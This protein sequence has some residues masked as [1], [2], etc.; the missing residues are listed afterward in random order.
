MANPFEGGWRPSWARGAAERGPTANDL[1][2]DV[3][4]AEEQST[5]G[6]MMEGALGGLGYVGSLLDK[7]FG[8]RGLRG[9]LG[10]RPEE[11]LS[12]IPFS[13]TL[14][15]TKPENEVTGRDLLA[16]TGL[17]SRRQPGESFSWSDDLPGMAAEILLDP[18][19]YLSLGTT[20]A[21]KAAKQAGTLAGGLK[22]ELRAGQR[23]LNW[24]LPFVMDDPLQV[25]SGPAFLD[26]MGW[27]RS[28]V[29]APTRGADWLANTALGVTPFA[30]AQRRLYDNVIEPVGRQ[31]NRL[32]APAVKEAAS[33]EG[34]DLGRYMTE[35]EALLERQGLGEAADR[36]AELAQLLGPNPTPD[37]VRDV[38]AALAAN[39]EYAEKGIV[40]NDLFKTAYRDT[41]DEMRK[42]LTKSADT[43]DE[44]LQNLN[45]W[46]NPVFNNPRGTLNA[47]NQALYDMSVTPTNRQFISQQLQN[48]APSIERTR[49]RDEALASGLKPAEVDNV[50]ALQDQYARGGIAAGNYQNIDD[51]YKNLRATSGGT[52]APG[53][54]LQEQSLRTAPVTPSST[55]LPPAYWASESG[56]GAISAAAAQK[57]ALR[58]AMNE[59]AARGDTAAAEEYLRLY[60]S[61]SDEVST[62]PRPDPAAALPLMDSPF[63]FAAGEDPATDTLRSLAKAQGAGQPKTVMEGL[64]VIGLS[65]SPLAPVA[66]AVLGV[67][68][69]ASLGRKVVRN[70]ELDPAYL[71]RQEKVRLP[72]DA[73]AQTAVHEFTHAATSNNL[74]REAVNYHLGIED[75]RNR[76]GDV[77][78]RDINTQAAT[79]NFLKGPEFARVLRNYASSPQVS[80]PMREII[81]SYLEAGK[82]L[83]LGPETRGQT[84]APPISGQKPVRLMNNPDAV[85]DSGLPYGISDLHEFMAEA[86]ANPA[87]QRMLD[88]IPAKLPDDLPTGML[89][90]IEGRLDVPAGAL[91]GTLLE[92]VL[93]ATERMM[94]TSHADALSPLASKLKAIDEPLLQVQQGAIRGSYEI[95]PGGERTIRALAMPDPSTFLHEVSHDFLTQIGKLGPQLEA[96]AYKALGVADASQ[97][98]VKHHEQFARGFEAYMR[99]GKSPVAGLRGVFQQFKNWL[100]NLYQKIRGTPLERQ[101]TPELRT[102]FDNMLKAGDGVI[103]VGAKQALPTDTASMTLLN[104]LRDEIDAGMLPKVLPGGKIALESGPDLLMKDKQFLAQQ[105]MGD[106]N[107]GPLSYGRYTSD[108]KEFRTQL[109]DWAANPATGLDD[110]LFSG[111]YGKQAD[112]AMLGAQNTGEMGRVKSLGKAVEY[113]PPKGEQHYLKWADTNLTDP[114]DKAAFDSLVAGEKQFL[115][116]L[117]AVEQATGAAGGSL[118]DSWIDYAY[119][120]KTRFPADDPRS[121]QDRS[122]KNFFRDLAA[123]NE[124]FNNRIKIFRDVPGGTE[125]INAMAMD[126]RLSGAARTAASD[127]QAEAIIREILTGTSAPAKGNPAYDQAKGLAKWAASLPPEHVTQKVPFFS[128]DLPQLML[129]RTR[130]ANQVV[131]IG[132]T[133][134]EAFQRYGDTTAGWNARGEKDLVSAA[135]LAR[136]MNLHGADDGGSVMAQKLY[137]LT[138]EF[139]MNSVL[140][141]SPGTQIK[142][143]ALKDLMVPRSLADDMLKFHAGY[144]NP[145]SVQPIL[146]IYDNVVGITKAYLTRPFVSFHTRNLL[147]NLWVA[148]R[149]GAVGHGFSPA[150]DLET[151]KQATEFVRGRGVDNLIPGVTKEGLYKELVQAGIYGPN[152]S[153][154]ADILGAGGEIVSTG[155]RKPMEPTGKSIAGDAWNRVKE[156][157]KGQPGQ[158]KVFG[159][160]A[161][162]NPVNP[163]NAL[164]TLTT[165]AGQ[166]IEDASRVFNYLGLRKRGWEPKAAADQ[167]QKYQIDYSKATNFERVVMKRIFPW[168]AF[169]KGSLPVVLED[170]LTQPG[171]IA[172]PLRALT[173][174]RAQGEFVPGYIGEGAAL[175]LGENPD[176]S[177]RYLSSFGLSIED[178]GLKM[179]GSLIKGDVGRAGEQALG[180]SYPWIKSPLELIFNKQLHSGRPLTDLKPYEF[181]SLGGLL[182]ERQARVLTEIGSNTPA[183]R[184]LS[185]VNRLGDERKGLMEQAWNLG[186]G[187]RI[188]DVDTRR[189]FDAATLKMLGDQLMGQAGIRSRSEVYAPVEGIPGMSPENQLKLALYQRAEQR[190]RDAAKARREAAGK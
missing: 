107:F 27:A 44:D 25:M 122:V 59:A 170:L 165:E 71:T 21:G 84:F 41:G 105:I 163:K 115:M 73:D 51:Y 126:P 98:T 37:R 62:L 14:G 93:G 141:V 167:V 175:P 45:S 36:Q 69:T 166:Q 131:A 56:M 182:N 184:F 151:W 79:E 110:P 67:A 38:Y 91:Q 18:S 83:G 77:T 136:Q 176:G 172:A 17:V 121:L 134:E 148:F 147:N 54:L 177:Q 29:T 99:T 64:G 180:M 155:L 47:R 181:A 112:R 150:K 22:S 129:Q 183:S 42:Y 157:V 97:L 120:Q 135:E 81:D 2:P 132:K 68:D 124:S 127:E 142:L 24:K 169:T 60:R 4:P 52:P 43:Y 8:A 3:N 23:A 80:G 100:T 125:T 90:G 140:G 74:D 39:M 19:T 1:L 46:M 164:L 146:D 94:A 145:R 49:F 114:A 82:R 53:A 15:F 101:L 162:F 109:Q 12:I 34:Q 13:D 154:S 187:V 35:L 9:V 26:T 106:Q 65:P 153:N 119:R 86:V 171:K 111:R 72:R 89:R 88:D 161:P 31:F 30:G 104:A 139:K 55:P 116:K 159:K 118:T 57:Q 66:E 28:G 138:S 5:I 87:F 160:D 16:D 61:I 128:V 173:G 152:T 168:Y 113:E 158:P 48:A 123:T 50:M 186:T 130:G 92:R 75:L 70:N 143:D 63:W 95:A 76:L 6:W 78:S 7:T 108:R 103:D 149:S 10:G 137:P 185:T 32:F 33:A 20:A 188:T 144:T 179:L 58:K 178:E 174:G 102:F 40:T 189:A 133:F 96:D 156:V 11:L 117:K 190:M 85:L